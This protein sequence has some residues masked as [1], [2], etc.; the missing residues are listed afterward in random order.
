MCHNTIRRSFTSSPIR[1]DFGP[2]LTFGV[3]FAVGSW[4]NYD[5]DW[6]RRS[7]YVGQWRPGWNHDRNWDR[8]DQG[9]NWNRGD[10]EPNWDRWSEGPERT[11]VIA[12]ETGIVVARPEQQHRQCRKHQQRHRASVATECEQPASSGA[13]PAQQLRKCPFCKRQCPGRQPPIGR[14]I[15]P[16]TDKKRRSAREPHSQA[17]TSQFH[18]PGESENSPWL[19]GFEWIQRFSRLTP[20]IQCGDRRC[21]IAR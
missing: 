14:T 16:Q 2:L 6:D 3:G 5:C 13:T 11:A 4:L 21:A 9:R 17:L 7:I 20:V 18:Q 8:W 15:H 12:A 1:E 19:A 10:R